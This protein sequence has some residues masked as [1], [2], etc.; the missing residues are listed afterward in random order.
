MG[1]GVGC[2]PSTVLAYSALMG[3]GKGKHSMMEQGMTSRT[4]SM[5]VLIN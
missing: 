5:L 4:V 2:F 3:M 1:I